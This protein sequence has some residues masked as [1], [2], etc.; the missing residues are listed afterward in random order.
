[1][2]SAYLHAYPYSGTNWQELEK[3]EI[4]SE[5]VAQVTKDIEVQ[6]LA[7]KRRPTLSLGLRGRPSFKRSAAER[8]APFSKEKHSKHRKRSV[9]RRGTHK[10]EC[11][12]ENKYWLGGW[13]EMHI[14]CANESRSRPVVLAGKTTTTICFAS[15]SHRKRGEGGGRREGEGSLH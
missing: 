11:M 4:N 2:P 7:K 15:I 1:M 14:S 13:H 3:N 9:S 10:I 8:D 5:W 12:D 6:L